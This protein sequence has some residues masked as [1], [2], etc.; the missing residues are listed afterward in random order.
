MKIVSNALKPETENEFLT[1]EEVATMLKIGKSTLE[2]M[3]LKGG[4][5]RFFKF[6]PRAIRYRI[7]DI[8]AWGKTYSSTSEYERAA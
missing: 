6:G 7:A 5:P 8:V 2:Q 4:G 3:R 1:T